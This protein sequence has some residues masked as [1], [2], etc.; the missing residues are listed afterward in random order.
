M[1]RYLIIDV[2]YY[3]PVPGDSEW[4]FEPTLKW[5]GDDVPQDLQVTDD[6]EP[7]EEYGEFS[8]IATRKFV[9]IVTEKGWGK[10]ADAWSLEVEDSEANMG[11]LTEY[12]W[13]PSDS[14]NIGGMDWNLGGVT[15]IAFVDVRVSPR[16]TFG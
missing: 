2:A 13:M 5:L 4:A 10:L 11:I 1:A 6:T 9:G 3:S 14:W 12:G 16:Y 8:N 15:P 7:G